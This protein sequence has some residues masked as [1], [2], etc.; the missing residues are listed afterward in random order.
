MPTE[1][2]NYK[3]TNEGISCVVVLGPKNCKDFVS[4]ID[5]FLT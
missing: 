5:S 3:L 4:Y 1:K 2:K